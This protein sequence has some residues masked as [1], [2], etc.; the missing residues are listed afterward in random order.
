MNDATSSSLGQRVDNAIAELSP[1]YFGMVMATGIVSLAAWYH[2]FGWIAQTLLWINAA[3]FAGFWAVNIVR[4]VRHPS[5][6]LNDLHR[7]TRGPGFFT[8]VAAAGVLGAQF[9]ALKGNLTVAITFWGLAALLWLLCTYGVFTLIFARVAKPPLGRGIHGGWLG[10]VVATQS[11][12]VLGA[13]IGP[14]MGPSGQ[15]ID[16]VTL[17]LWLFGGT[18][19]LWLISIIFYR[20]AFIRFSPRDL[21][22]P[23]WIDMGA[24]AISTVAGAEL[25]HAA[26]AGKPL[27]APL[28]P[29]IHGL[30][31]TFWATATWWIPL[32]VL[33]EIWRHGIERYPI[34]Y[35]LLHWEG[36]FPLGMY[37]VATYALAEMVGLEFLHPVAAA[38]TYVALLAWIVVF[39]GWVRAMGRVLT[40]RGSTAAPG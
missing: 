2:G 18:L 30:T 3:L 35:T 13:R 6:V 19:Y 24:M 8:W 20:Y 7:H 17:I 1:A 38:F 28:A 31:L 21:T 16:F 25:Y 40:G 32:L 9:I 11:V 10:A 14:N 26:V 23:Y 27:L 15:W 12:A 29:Y 34:A 33:L 4:I 22:P 36:V 37:T 39:I 5:R